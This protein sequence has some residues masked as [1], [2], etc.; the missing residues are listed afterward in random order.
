MFT[1]NAAT[2]DSKKLDLMKTVY[3]TVYYGADTFSEGRLGE[4]LAYLMGAILTDSVCE[5]DEEED[6]VALLR[7]HFPLEHD[8]W[9]Y[10]DILP[11]DALGDT[12]EVQ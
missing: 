8:V 10:I 11:A 4:D 3:Q 9:G 7:E 2:T 1:L 12:E 5:W 6:L